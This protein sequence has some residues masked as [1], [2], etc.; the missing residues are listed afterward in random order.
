[1]INPTLAAQLFTA[2]IFLN[3]LCGCTINEPTPPSAQLPEAA[4]TS[5]ELTLHPDGRV[6]D[7]NFL[8]SVPTKD[9]ERL[10]SNLM[11]N[12]RA[13]PDKEGK[14][15]TLILRTQPPR[16]RRPFRPAKPLTIKAYEKL[17]ARLA[18]YEKQGHTI[19]RPRVLSLRLPNSPRPFQRGTVKAHLIINE[20]GDVNQMLVTGDKAEVFLPGIEAVRC[21][22]QFKPGTVNGLP[23]AFPYLLPLRFDHRPN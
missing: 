5:I 1:M 3:G 8:G 4:F 6:K 16:P 9:Q 17:S 18:E 23:Y 19:V 11:K 12:F 7:I 2:L 21:D 10:R 14:S 22:W 15:K 20:K 13:T